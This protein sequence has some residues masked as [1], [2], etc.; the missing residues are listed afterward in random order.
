MKSI[1][2]RQI[3]RLGL[4]CSS[5]GSVIYAGVR[6]LKSCGYDLVAA[7]VTD[8]PCGAEKICTELGVPFIRIE[9]PRREEF[10][11]KAAHWLYETNEVE[12]TA[13]FFSRMVGELLY[14]GRYCVNI[15]PSL[16]PAFPG[17]GALSA[18]IDTNVKFFGATAHLVDHTMDG[19]PVLA[20]V[21]GPVPPGA[22]IG[23]LER[24][25]YAQKLYLF[26]VL[27]E[28]ASKGFFSVREKPSVGELNSCNYS[29]YASP[30]IQDKKL[31][32]AFLE[33]I[34]CEGIKW[35]Y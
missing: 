21:T 26:I 15:H 18:L 27:C 6:I 4:V 24:I 3:V 8:R 35:P 33:H 20:Q 2:S 17:M 19:G 5:G 13:L 23:G 7:V 14:S 12:W 31:E 1:E 11:S 16:L 28:I 30:K 34:K 25:S 22:T 9:D 29:N 10:T 32:G